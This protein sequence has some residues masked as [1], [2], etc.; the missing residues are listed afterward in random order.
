MHF[1]LLGRVFPQNPYVVI[2]V[3]GLEHL[4]MVL[5][6]SHRGSVISLQGQ[7]YDR[8]VEQGRLELFKRFLLYDQAAKNQIV[9]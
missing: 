1:K 7:L 3:A 6:C 5:V 8:K 2:V 4:I 9:D